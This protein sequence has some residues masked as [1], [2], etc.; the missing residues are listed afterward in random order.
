M[1]WSFS[2]TA[3][4]AIE[5][6]LDQV[7]HLLRDVRNFF[8]N[9]LLTSLKF[10]SDILFKSLQGRDVN[11]DARQRDDVVFAVLCNSAGLREPAV[12]TILDDFGVVSLA[13]TVPGEDL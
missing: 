1:T 5:F 11:L 7:I 12:A 4:K 13:T 3:K 6:F 2:V 8:P 9:E 10:L